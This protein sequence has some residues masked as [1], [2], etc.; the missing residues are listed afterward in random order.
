MVQRVLEG[1]SMRIAPGDTCVKAQANVN[2]V[3]EG[4][5]RNSE[6]VELLPVACRVCAHITEV[7]AQIYVDGA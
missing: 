5:K 1:H 2:G 3:L 4:G 6:R 7:C